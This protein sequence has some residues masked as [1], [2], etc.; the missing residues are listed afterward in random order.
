MKKQ[1]GFTLV[2]FMVAMAVTV[3][4]LGAAVMAF[5]D[6][7]K[8]S[9]GV[10]LQSDMTDNLRAGLN[11]I[12]QDLIQTGTGIPTGGISIPNTGA[13]GAG[14]S[15]GVSNLI[16]PALTASSLI[17]PK[18]N[19]V[20]P[21]LNPGSALGVLISSPDAT[22]TTNTDIVSMLYADNSSA[23]AA[24]K[25]IGMDS[26]PV[27]GASCPAGKIDK[28]GLYLTFDTTCFNPATLPTYGI[29]INP[30]DLILFSNA[31]GNALQTVTSVSGSTLNF[32]SGDG[33]GLNASGKPSG[34]LIQLQNYNVDAA[35]NRVYNVGTYPPTTV[36]RIWMISYY[37]DNT[38]DAAHVRLI[39]RVNFNTG[40]AVSETIEN[41]Q[42][43][44]NFVN[45]S[46]VL[47]NQSAVPTGYSENQ[48]RN[49]TVNLGARSDTPTTAAGNKVRYLRTNLQ[50]QV[51]IRSLA[52]F[53]QYE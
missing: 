27:N 47:P 52:Y 33:F 42:L 28:N 23:T 2:E 5:R 16:R 31:N 4:V 40:Y 45:G 17:F 22:S 49:V 24:G 19:I 46:T 41:L 11:L 35:G 15:S 8:S 34:T 51:T 18:C 48:I 21:A 20:L 12:Q 36:T 14:C 38:T 26:A 39:R 10:S 44:Y 25:N 1:H 50:T 53:S 32:N 37:L 3:V 29:A 9:Q 30:N 7:A 6:T 43:T 13:A